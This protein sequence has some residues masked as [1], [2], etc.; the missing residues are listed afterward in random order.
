MFERA[1]PVH[2][3]D[4]AAPQIA[5]Q[6]VGLLEIRVLFGEFDCLKG[7]RAVFLYQYLTKRKLSQCYGRAVW[8]I[9][10][11]RRL[12]HRD[13][14][15]ELHS[16]HEPMCVYPVFVAFRRN[17]PRYNESY[18]PCIRLRNWNCGQGQINGWRT[19]IQFNSILIY[20]YANLTLR[21]QLQ[22]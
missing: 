4:R 3:S 6:N 21:S 8:G 16:R 1:R 9:N 7:N 12:K 18:R 14:G 10:C 19:I 17:D 2:S 15:F 22:S 20:W 11:L 13:R 5:A